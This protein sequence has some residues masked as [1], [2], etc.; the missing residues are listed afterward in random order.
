MKS[1]FFMIMILSLFMTLIGIVG[2]V[3][4]AYFFVEGAVHFAKRLNFS[5]LFIGLTV[6]AIG[7][8]SPEL[9]FTAWG[10]V[11]GQG[12]VILGNIIGSNIFNT[13]T[14]L[15]IASLCTPI[16][17]RKKILRWD[18]PICIG[19]TFLFWLLTY[20]EKIHGWEGVLLILAFLLYTLFA[21]KIEKN[22]DAIELPSKLLSYP[23]IFLYLVLGTAIL[24][25][26]SDLLIQGVVLLGKTAHINPLLLSLIVVS[27]GTSLPELAVTLQSVKKN[28]VELAL[29]NILGSNLFNLLFAGGIGA[30]F[31][32]NGLVVPEALRSFDLPVL[33]AG[34][35]FLFPLALT[36]G[37]LARWE[38]GLLFFYY[39]FYLFW[40]VIRALYAPWEPILLQAFIYFLAPLTLFTVIVS[41]VRHFRAK[42]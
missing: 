30:L 16:V 9:F 31:S 42:V 18:I 41:L 24:L 40:V 20:G 32:P 1:S 35:L 25:G 21:L 34:T 37:H 28:E 29:G 8:S 15:G 17:V 11:I 3:I 33:L 2:L 6:A 5:P 22:E 7:T 12:D 39:L 14:I 26:G 23:L 13:M 4:G 27:A 19:A 10:A 38:G 36:G